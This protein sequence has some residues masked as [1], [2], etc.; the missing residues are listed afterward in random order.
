VRRIAEIFPSIPI[1]PAI[2]ET[3]GE[4]KTTLVKVGTI[5][6]DMDLLIEST[7]LSNNL[8]LVTKNTKHFEKIS[9]LEIENWSA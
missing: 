2:M 9:G 3:L 8:V 6:D 4:L 7:A 1:T 5:L